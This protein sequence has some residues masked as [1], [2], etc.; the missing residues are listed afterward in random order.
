MPTPRGNNTRLHPVSATG[1]EISRF[2]ENFL[3]G[4]RSMLLEAHSSKDPRVVQLA[5]RV[6]ALQ[7]P[8]IAQL[9][10]SEEPSIARLA[11][12]LT[13]TGM[14]PIRTELQP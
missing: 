2:E 11:K 7:K 5:R 10:A 9:L 6:L 1:N 13:S 4:L 3:A 14:A 8:N 12:S